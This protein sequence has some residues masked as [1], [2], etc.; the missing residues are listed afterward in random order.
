MCR[1]KIIIYIII[2]LFIFILFTLCNR[3][4]NNKCSVVN[5]HKKEQEL[6]SSM[7]DKEKYIYLNS[8]DEIKNNILNQ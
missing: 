4:K 1:N 8:S 6:F 3:K 2:I 7:N 5:L